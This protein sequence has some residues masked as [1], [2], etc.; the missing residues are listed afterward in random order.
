[1]A[2]LVSRA[3]LSERASFV[4]SQLP[5]HGFFDGK[6]WRVAAQAFPLGPAH[7]KILD[8]LGRALHA[9]T[10]ACNLLYRYS[11]EGRQPAWI[12]ELLDAGK[13]PELIEIS[14]SAA[15]RAELPVVIRPDLVL[16]NEGF[17]LTELDS[18]PGGIGLTSWLAQ[19]YCALGDRVIGGPGGMRAGFEMI[20]P[21]GHCVISEEAKDYRPEMEW[22]LG[23]GRVRNAESYVADGSPIYRFFEAFDWMR[24]ES[25]RLSWQPGQPMTP[26]LKP[27]LEEKLWLAL[28][29]LRPL[30][31]FWR[32]QISEK[33]LHFLQRI[34]PYSW[35]V[36][37]SPLPPHAVIPGL[38]IHQWSE[39]ARFSQRERE[40]VLKISGFSE[41]A[42]GARGVWIG[43]D[44]SG[45][46]WSDCVREALEAC[47]RQPRVLQRFV[48]GSVVEQVY[49]DADHHLHVLAGRARV[50]PYYFVH[51]GHPQLGGVLV[52]LCP[53][54]K[55]ILHG[56]SDAVL[57]PA[58]V[59][60][61]AGSEA[62]IHGS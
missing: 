34:I 45:A 44:M 9:F 48:A 6:R 52:T 60:S 47:R 39:M 2:S 5:A 33:G 61:P 22:L 42:W 7:V 40:L 38:D 49:A 26:P 62:R 17:V 57:S 10:K 32:Q 53:K 41:L 30:R 13:P 23:P 1:M 37:P 27:F 20:F 14:R 29:W 56:M 15:L 59:A 31:E 24:L 4:R 21:S 54:D 36:D 50:S 25:L 3:G 58:A 8:R 16:T 12:H 28:F 55:K 35:I 46:E 11:V 43:S 51:D 19:T 18:V